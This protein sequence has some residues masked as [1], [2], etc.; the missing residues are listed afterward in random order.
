MKV[1]FEIGEKK[2]YIAPYN[3]AQEKEILLSASFEMEDFE[4]IFEILG[5]KTDYELSTDE[6]KAILY[7][8]REISIG[9]EVDTKY[10]CDS[11][12]NVNDG[13]LD[14]S[15]FIVEPKRND[16]DIKDLF[17]VPSLS[18][19]SK[20]V[21]LSEEELD[22]LEMDEY[23]NLLQRIKENQS[24]FNFEKTHMCM[25]C[26]HKTK[27][28]MSDINYII[29]IMSDDTLMTLYKTYNFLIFYSHYTKQ[30]I[31]SMYPFERSIFI[32]LL[33]KTKEE[34]AK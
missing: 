14:A 30:D 3:T 19:M 15:N 23:E 10:Q 17:S 34:L 31:D 29:D 1:K 4:N 12:G 26:G 33:N 25:A 13:T 18:N 2:F 22:E 27:F 16:D 20:F 7:K 24:S 9:D 32:G 28:D 6:K 5:F 8:F 21:S 11:C